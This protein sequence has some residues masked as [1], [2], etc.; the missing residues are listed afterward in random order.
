MK[1]VVTDLAPDSIFNGNKISEKAA[2][3]TVHPN[4]PEILPVIM[5][6][7]TEQPVVCFFVDKN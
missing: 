7:A 4:L 5:S 1:F 2:K 6:E 3:I